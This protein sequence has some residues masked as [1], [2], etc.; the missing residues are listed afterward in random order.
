[1]KANRQV[2]ENKDAI[3]VSRRLKSHLLIVTNRVFEFP[4]MHLNQRQT[5]LLQDHYYNRYQAFCLEQVSQIPGPSLCNSTLR[6]STVKEIDAHLLLLCT[7]ADKAS[8]KLLKGELFK[9][10]GACVGMKGDKRDC[11]CLL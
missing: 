9:D 3:D 5:Y 2:T 4:V 11:A 7:L 6:P 1:L 10:K 8:Q